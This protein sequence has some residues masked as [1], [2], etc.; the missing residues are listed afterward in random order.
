ME[1][2]EAEPMRIV[3]RKGAKRAK[4]EKTRKVF[5]C[6]LGVPSTMFNA[7]LGENPF[8]VVGL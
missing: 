1:H 4:A 7:G 3:S 2:G 5:R 8:R 6:E